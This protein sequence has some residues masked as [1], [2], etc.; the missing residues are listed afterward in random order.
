MTYHTLG[1]PHV[2]LHGL[3]L[4]DPSQLAEANP[5]DT[6]DVCLVDLDGEVARLT[7]RRALI[8]IAH[9]HAPAIVAIRWPGQRLHEGVDASLDLRWPIADLVTVLVAAG[10]G[11]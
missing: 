4:A 5:D 8:R 7:G 10:G 6:A 3:H 11:R 2:V 1:L 9:E